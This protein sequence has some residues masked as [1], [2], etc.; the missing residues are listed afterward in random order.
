VSQSWGGSNLLKYAVLKGVWLCSFA[1]IRSHLYQSSGCCLIV[2][3]SSNLLKYAV[4][5]AFW[6]CSFVTIR[7]HHYQSCK[8]AVWLSLNR[9][10]CL[11]TPYLWL[12][13]FA[14]LWSVDP[15]ITKVEGCCLIVTQSSN[16]LKHP[17][18]KGS[19]F[20]I[21]EICDHSIP[22]LPK[23]QRCWLT[24]NQSSNRPKFDVLK[25]FW[26]PESVT[27]RSHHY[28]TVYY[29]ISLPLFTI[30]CLWMNQIPT[31]FWIS[32]QPVSRYWG[33]LYSAYFGA[34]TIAI[35]WFWGLQPFCY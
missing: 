1:T 9:Q 34:T 22:S 15:T 13:H 31:M 5:K 33:A 8:G 23:L 28:Q 26:L 20:L 32:C 14:H 21:P 29:S 2:T 19:W 18:L 7:S 17:V 6:L 3:Q 11:S 24:V 27:V 4:L 35:C 30:H 25:G 12:F 10:T 16:L